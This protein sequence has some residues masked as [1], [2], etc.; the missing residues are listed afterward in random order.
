VKVDA[1]E[2]HRVC[3]VTQNASDDPPI[4]NRAVLWADAARKRYNCDMVN[5]RRLLSSQYGVVRWKATGHYLNSASGFRSIRQGS[6]AG[7]CGGHVL[8][9]MAGAHRAHPSLA[10][11]YWAQ[12]ICGR[13]LQP[14]K[15]IIARSAA[16]N[17]QP[18]FP[19]CSHPNPI[20]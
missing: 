19:L 3:G 17:F 11:S 13:V 16:H 8:P 4:G 2:D 6:C 12:T 14:R 5:R 7:S 20:A 9:G 15:Y 10:I 1:L 18:D